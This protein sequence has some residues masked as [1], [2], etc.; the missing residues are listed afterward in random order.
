MKQMSIEVWERAI[1][2]C[3]AVFDPAQRFPAVVQ[4][5]DLAPL[6]FFDGDFVFSAEAWP[7]IR[8]LAELH[9][10]HLVRV[11][12]MDPGPAHYEIAIGT[13]GGFAIS[14][15]ANSVAYGQ[16]LYGELQ[17]DSKGLIGYTGQVVAVFG[18]SLTW[19]LWCERNVAGLV[20]TSTPE[21]LWQWQVEY[22]P[23]LSLEDALQGFLSVNLGPGP[24]PERT[25]FEKNYRTFG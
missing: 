5:L 4:Q 2:D 23:F 9:G 24:S 22:G 7:M 11:V 1:A 25:G 18:E 15:D 10:D 12:V 20:A 8:S 16:G 21:L 17:A 6:P 3:T 19:G 14:T 13:A